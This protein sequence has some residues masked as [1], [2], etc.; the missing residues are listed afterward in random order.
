MKFLPRLCAI[1]IVL[2][3]GFGCS[4]EPS[5]ETAKA[6]NPAAAPAPAQVL[7]TPLI[8]FPDI[9]KFE[10]KAPNDL[11]A[12]ST[13][14]KVIRS[15]VPQAQLKCMDE[16]LDYM[17]DLQ[18]AKDGSVTAELNGSH[19]DNFMVGYVNASPTGEINIVLQ[20]LPPDDKPHL[21]FTNRNIAGE[22]PAALMNWYYMVAGQQDVVRVSNG[23]ETRDI[24]YAQFL[25]ETLAG[26]AKPLQDQGN[27]SQ[28]AKLKSPEITKPDEKGKATQSD[29]VTGEWMCDSNSVD[30]SARTFFL[31]HGRQ[32]AYSIGNTLRMVSLSY[33]SS[34]ERASGT[35]E[36]RTFKGKTTQ[37]SFPYELTFRS[38]TPDRL[39]FDM[40][41]KGSKAELLSSNDC[42]PL[43][44]QAGPKSKPK[45]S[46]GG[47][48]V[49]AYANNLAS[50]LER[51]SHPT[52][53]MLANSIRSFGNSGQPDHVRM[54]QVDNLFNK[55]PG[56]C[57]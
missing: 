24:P 23:K 35:F 32:F 46:G 8:P 51:S 14:G 5:S 7:A 12:D 43:V 56:I 41:V 20:C 52:C 22:A 48:K 6:Q 2:G 55:A 29:S 17:P 15:I 45:A 53:Q 25:K 57:H 9:A 30:G 16:I 40:K 33:K 44:D 37:E 18:L 49:A 50:E 13:I 3:T 54:R 34:G 26:A 36:E 31:F 11:V 42:V 27:T 28:Q 19:A 4:K 10:K 38:S 1:A 39:V 47:D 21:Y